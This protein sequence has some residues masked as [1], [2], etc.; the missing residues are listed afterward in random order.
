MQNDVIQKVKISEID[1]D[2][3]FFQSLKEDYDGFEGW[4][5]RKSNEDAYIFRENANLAGFLYLK[6]EDEEDFS[7]S[8]IFEK[9]RRLK[10]GTF[11]IE[12]HGTVLGQRY[13]SII[14]RRM[15]NEGHNF[16]YVTLFEKQ[17]GL[18]RLFEKF[19]FRKWGT[20]GN[21][22]LVYYRDIEV[23]NDEYKDFPLINTRNNPRK[24]LLSIYPI[25]HTKLFPDSK[26]HT[27]RNH[28]VEDLSFTNTVE[29][30]YICAIPNVME[31]KKGDLI[32]IYRTA[33]Y[34]KPAEFSS[35]ASSICTVIEVRNINS[36]STLDDFLY[37]S[38]KGSI[39]S[40]DELISFW[41]TKKYPYIIKML[42]N[43][44]L[45]NRVIRKK[46]IDEVG[47]SRD[48]R[49]SCIELQDMQFNKLLEIGEVHEGFII[50]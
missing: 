50:D 32:V 16:T 28:I 13:L 44:P 12:T 1:I 11:K 20:K 29:K 35:V 25:F 23:F 18:I 5:S 22:E 14:L 37:Y 15:F 43:V 7:V 45:T 38:G 46:L 31:M 42:Y 30:I 27:E 21:G 4:F 49:W 36:F 48:Q 40:K 17:Q 9:Q 24:F 34:G 8:P 33:E 2:D 10:I 6:D 47:L 26:L 41:N 19:G 39:F 3:T